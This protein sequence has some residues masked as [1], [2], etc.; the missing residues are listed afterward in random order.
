MTNQSVSDLVP[1]PERPALPLIGHA[2]DVPSG[3]DGLLYLMKEAKE[4]GPLFKLKAF[5]TEMTF[6][7]G[8]DLVDEISDQSRFRKNL[9]PDLLSLRA[10]GRDGLFTAHN[11][12]PNWRK[13][14]DVLMPAFSLGAMRDYHGTML[15]VARD[16]IA[17]WD[18]VAG[19]GSVDVA[20]DMTRLTFD[21]IGLCG[22]EYDFES[23]R[24][25]ELHPFVVA[26][27]RAMMYV[28]IK[29]ES[30]PGTEIFRWKQKE[31]FEEDVALM[32]ELVDDVI[33]RRKASGDT[34]TA[35]LLGRMLHVRD[36]E[37]GEPLDDLN[38]RYQVITFLVAGHETTSGLLSF[39]LYY[40][41][42]HPEILARAQAEVD[43]LWGDTDELDPQYAD[44][45][46]LQYIRQ[47]LNETLRLWPTAPGFA[48][49]AL[50]DTVIGGKYA[51]RKGETL[52]VTIPA[53]HREPA[54]GDNVELFDPERFT[55]E[56][57]AAR[58]AQA[59]KPFGTGDRACIGR[60][61][62]LHEATLVLAM[63]VHRYR[64]IDHTAYE[65]KVTQGLTIK[66]EDF[67]LKLVRRQTDERRTP[68]TV[69][70]AHAERGEPQTSGTRAAGTGLRVLHGSNLG[71]CVGIAQD[72]AGEADEY[73]F[74]A[75]AAPLN[76]AAGRLADEEGPV[77]IVAAS[78]NGRPTDDADRFVSWLEELEPGS[79]DGLSYAVLGVGDRNWAATY[80]RIPTLIDERL[81]AAGATRLVERAAADA[82]G[83]FG[84]AVDRFT[85]RLWTTLLAEYGSAEASDTTQRP[86]EATDSDQGLYELQEA[87]DSVTGELAAR[88]G[89]QPMEVLDAYELVDM[90][91]PLGRSKRFLKLRLPDGVTYRTGDH[92][93]VLP[94][95]PDALV[96]RVTDRFGLDLDR[97]VRLRARRR[98]RNALPVDRPLTLRRL[99]TDF[100]ELQDPATQEQVAVLAEHTTCP[101]EKKPLTEL[102]TAD[103]DTFHE[104]VTAVGRSVLDLVERYAACEVPFERFLELL[105]V[106]RSRHYSISSSAEASPGEVDLM[107]S[108]LAQP[109]RGGEG[110]FTGIASHYLQTITAGDTIQA[111]VLPCREDFRLPEDSTAPV[112]LV[113]AGTGL[114]PFRGAVLDRV[115]RKI[116]TGTALVYFGCDHPEVDYLHRDELE[117]AE[118]AGAVQLRPAFMHAPENGRRFVQ[119]RILND[120]QEVWDAIEAGGR[121]Y[122]C[123]DGRRMAPAVREAFKTIYCDKTGSSYEKATTWL[124]ALVESGHYNEDVWAG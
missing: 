28:Q 46:K 88:H 25:D 123:G 21:T 23:L 40:L 81:A 48:R 65:L 118:R 62:A 100:V 69:A 17:R 31:Q 75:S 49:E 93:A 67:T 8:M 79:L 34:S 91:D 38:I 101:P 112:I 83:D 76:D 80:Q 22:F 96:Q 1:I 90:D 56:R 24:G 97:T 82:S 33:A 110:T 66:P 115:H 13:A 63:L 116:T 16:L 70:E 55:P 74:S 29:N 68:V 5:G 117:A 120:T 43:A 109:H 19:D 84:G 20:A 52:M 12:E 57:E 89:V 122:I 85:S 98:S 113:S 6:V 71:T 103:A 99:L 41:T 124:E 104:Q 7:H 60:Q 45:G 94:Q 102:A 77:V 39:A 36:E 32:N 92:F 47:I 61:F 14:H 58:P 50:E 59:F 9:H 4:L 105:P 54:W 51:V 106:L 111:R 108:L 72:L 42:K 35:D 26:L 18:G 37:T 30:I 119:D 107:V 10:M 44:I 86:A 15:K 78:Y 11:D 114:A 73:G 3:F 121:V 87:T 27:A 64:F 53:L 2:L 95:N